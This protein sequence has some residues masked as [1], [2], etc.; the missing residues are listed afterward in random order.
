MIQKRYYLVHEARDGCEA[1]YEEKLVS[2]PRQD[3]S[4]VACMRMQV[5]A[6][7][8]ASRRPHHAETERQGARKAA[9][10]IRDA[11]RDAVKAEGIA[12][13]AEQVKL[14]TATVTCVTGA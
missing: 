2:V 9:K 10:R 8:L 7:M 1:V 14:H 5:A 13:V 4:W 6:D 12:D 11:G 3:A